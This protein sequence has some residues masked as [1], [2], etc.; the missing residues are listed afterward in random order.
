[1]NFLLSW[2]HWSLALLLYLHHAKWSQ[3]A[4]MAEGEQKP[5]EVV[6]FMDVYQRSYC[7]PI[8]TLVDIFQ[9]YP[10]EI[11]YIFKPSCVPL[12]R[13]GGCCNDEGL[14]CVPTEEFNITMQIM[15]I[16]PHQGQHIG[17]MSFLQHNKCECRPKK[18]RARQE[19]PCG[20][21]SER[22]KHLFVQDPQTCKCSCKN[23]DSRCKA[24][25][26]ELNERTCRCDKP[27]R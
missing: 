9:E 22:R 3:A 15:R 21:C 19:N 26:L 8:E 14:E 6:K 18:D 17:E 12:M 1:M 13:C 10:D 23:T 4:P 27:R 24:R 20:P 16:K 11:E 5:H 7:R 2:V 25:Q